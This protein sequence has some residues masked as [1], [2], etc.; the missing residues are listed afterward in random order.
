M[1]RQNTEDLYDSETF[2]HDMIMEHMYCTFVNIHRRS[3]TK[4]EP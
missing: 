4:S 1:K 2:L 3:K